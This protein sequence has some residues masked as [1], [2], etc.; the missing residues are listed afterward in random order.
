MIVDHTDLIEA[1]L[2]KKKKAR[3]QL[4]TADFHME[5]TRG[6]VVFKTILRQMRKSIS[7]DFNKST[8]YMSA[9]GTSKHPEFLLEMIDNYLIKFNLTSRDK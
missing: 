7:E 3:T 6:D 4:K 2:D 1:T 9:K 8:H 5:K